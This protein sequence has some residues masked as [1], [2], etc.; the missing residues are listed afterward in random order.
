MKK[1]VLFLIA[2]TAS[3]CL[4]A[5]TQFKKFKI[6]IGIGYA[7]PIDEQANDGGLIYLEPAYRL[8]DAIAVGIR[9]ETFSANSGS[10]KLDASS[11][12]TFSIN[13]QYYFNNYRLR[14]FV[15]GGVGVYSLKGFTGE[16]ETKS[17]IGLYPRAGVDF[18]NLNMYIDYNIIPR[19][20]DEA[21]T[22]KTNY[23]GLH[24]GISI[25]GGRQ[26]GARH[27]PSTRNMF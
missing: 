18:G 17:L 11:I 8:T 26:I 23:F 4:S 21:K 16:V 25:G 12:G 19:F 3:S 15:G 20:N 2:L 1:Y 6:G 9:V 10:A 5:Q 13:G 22:V 27:R 24:M 7:T 14:G